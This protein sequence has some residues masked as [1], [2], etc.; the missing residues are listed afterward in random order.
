MVLAQMRVWPSVDGCRGDI[1]QSSKLIVSVINHDI[2]HQG[3]GKPHNLALAHT[4]GI[5]E[6]QLPHLLHFTSDE[7]PVCVHVLFI[8]NV[9]GT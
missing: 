6:P 5:G 9:E 1:T 3:L 2:S 7:P 4:N 8:N